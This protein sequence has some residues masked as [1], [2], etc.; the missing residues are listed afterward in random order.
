MTAGMAY[1]AAKSAV[2][3]IT[4]AAARQGVASGITVNALSPGALTRMSRPHLD[5][6]GIPPGLDLSPGQIARV[7]V[8]LCSE[9]LRHV[10]GTVVHTAAGFVRARRSHPRSG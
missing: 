9:R 5:E 1:A 4:M 7:T 10:T 8:A 2:W 3:G 6:A